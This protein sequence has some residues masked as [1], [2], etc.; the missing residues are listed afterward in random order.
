MRAAG[1]RARRR[2][3]RRPRTTDSGHALPVSPNV[4]AQR[5]TAALPNRVW[6]GDITYVPT[7]EGWLY[8]AVLVDLYSR[9]VV[10]WAL[11]RVI[12]RSLVL[13]A[14]AMALDRRKPASKL[15]H[16]TDRGSQ[17]AS[18][19]YQLELEAAGLRCSMS[20]RGNC[21]DNAVAESF[22]ATL[23]KERVHHRRWRT[24]EQ[25][26]SDLFEYIEGFYNLRRRHSAL[27]YR[28]PV[29]YEEAMR[30]A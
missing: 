1:L 13:R 11:D 28:S 22:F 4:L 9:R 19:D 15:L 26:Q 16:H 7:G 23:K 29:E 5:F 20:R 14:L 25:A 10:G 17:Y 24:R 27:G 30:V 21:Y 12:D 18:T 2:P 6:V 3:R 8:L